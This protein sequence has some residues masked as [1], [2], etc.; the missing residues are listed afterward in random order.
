MP[1]MFQEKQKDSV[2]EAEKISRIRNEVKEGRFGLILVSDKENPAHICASWG[3]VFTKSTHLKGATNGKVSH[4]LHP[5][6]RKTQ[7][8]RYQSG[9]SSELETT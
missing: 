9:S 3:S 7:G 6:E 8:W 5:I 4:L 2:A 1:D